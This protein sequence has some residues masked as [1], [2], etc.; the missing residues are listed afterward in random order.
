[1]KALTSTR[2]EPNAGQAKSLVEEV[3]KITI[4]RR[5]L[6]SIESHAISTYPE[7]CCGLL[8]GDFGSRNSSKSVA[9]SRR[10]RNAFEPSERYHRYTIDPRE[11]LDAEKEAE[12]NNEE[13]VGIYHSH[14]NARAAPSQFDKAHAWPMLSY[15]IVEVV[16]GKPVDFKSWVLSDDQGSFKEE[17]LNIVE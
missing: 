6:D 17:Q 11:F 10:M 1:V 3:S 4:P 9:R 5:V 14:P 8:F 7:E 13:I 12:A 2:L 15:L 16:G